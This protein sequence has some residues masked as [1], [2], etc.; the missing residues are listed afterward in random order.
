[1][2]SFTQNNIHTSYYTVR[3]Y[4]KRR[5]ENSLTYLTVF[6]IIMRNVENT[7]Y[8]LHGF[9]SNVPIP[10]L[11]LSL[12]TF[13]TGILS[14]L[15]HS[16]IFYIFFFSLFLSF[17]FHDFH[18]KRDTEENGKCVSSL[19]LLISNYRE[20][21]ITCTFPPFHSTCILYECINGKESD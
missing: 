4:M 3:T 2:I 12:F 11:P 18:M 19:P 10:T 20:L 16:W 5:R 13:T 6:Y 14:C 9:V 7:N 21:H 17:F 8:L 1:M 15:I